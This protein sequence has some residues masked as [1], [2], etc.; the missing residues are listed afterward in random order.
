[1]QQIRTIRTLP[2]ALAGLLGL[3]LA[4]GCA[5]YQGPRIDPTGESLIIWP[6][7]PQPIAPVPTPM[8]VGPPIVGAPIV[9]P[10]PTVQPLATVVPSTPFGNLLAPPVYSDPALPAVPL[11]ASVPPP[12]G[13]PPGA[14]APGLQ[15]PP[16]PV[17]VPTPVAPTAAVVPCGCDRLQILPATLVAPVGRE[18][19]MKANV[20]AAEGHARVNQRID[21]HIAANSVG[22]FTDMGLR[23]RGQIFGLL[24]I[25]HKLDE[26]SATSSTAVVPITLNTGSDGPEDDI[27]IN[28]GDAWVTLVSP[29]EG[30][31]VITANAPWLD[32]YNQASAT[33]YWV[34][35]Q[36]IFN[37]A[38][39]AAPGQPT[40]LT[41]TV[42]RRSDGAPLAGWIVRYNVS[43]NAALG[44]EGGAAV[45]QT[46]DAA[47]RASVEVSP[48]DAAGGVTNVGMTI[49]RPENIGPQSMPRLEV[50]RAATTITWGAVAGPGMPAPSLPPAPVTPPPYTPMPS[51]QPIPTPPP[52]LPPAPIQPGSPT[53]PPPP[54]YT[55]STTADPYSAP[56]ATG[57]KPQLEISLRQ[58]DPQQVAVGENVKW[59]LTVTNRGTAIA[60]GIMI[61]DKFD[62]GLVHPYDTQ[63]AYEIQYPGM[64]ALP[65]GESERL[66]LTFK[67]VDGGV[68][69]HEVTVSANSADTVSQRASIT[70]RQPA[71][72]VEIKNGEIRRVVGETATFKPT[73][74]NTG[75][76]AATKIELVARLDPAF[77]PTN[78][79]GS[80]GLLPNNQVLWRIDRLEPGELRQLTLEA[81]CVA[82]NSNARAVFQLVADGG[83]NAAAEAV[84][85]VLPPIGATGP[86]GA[87]APGNDLQ[88]AVVT[89]TNPGRVGQKQ[90]VNI[91]ISNPGQQIEKQVSMRVLL[92]Q[93]LTVDATQIQPAGEATIY[94]QEIRFNTIAELAPGQQRQYV[95][96]VTPNRTISGIQVRAELAGGSLPATKTVESAPIEILGAP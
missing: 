13:V 93:E 25:P 60:S 95:I 55:P 77:K 67:V 86:G 85:E 58:L 40:T 17:V 32:A 48:K 43:G 94:G 74:R 62:R 14:P 3:A 70:A 92:P 57:G 87:T 69:S 4:S 15:L 50:G 65:P 1:M 63:H 27:Q 75:D 28:Q 18:M 39:V 46:T 42:M 41:T 45:D 12:I 91:T 83:V 79:T 38:T 6:G 88:L 10:P 78:A 84:V 2:F 52:A 82:P 20:I 19:L 29:N 34:D 16:P 71:L 68:Q 53:G 47:G 64:R 76:V 59:E 73:I 21:W 7:E 35:A 81:T 23:D 49:I 44:Y 5:M 80:E 90:L 26:W 33:I 24:E 37:Q 96:P 89:N 11:V 54:A 30:V 72:T 51:G 56:T 36:W 8:V 9:A 22:Q 31:T 61:R 66:P